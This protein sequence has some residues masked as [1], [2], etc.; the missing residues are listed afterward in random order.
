M[1]ER[2]KVRTRVV[3]LLLTVL[4]AGLPA[5]EAGKSKTPKPKNWLG[6]PSHEL[7]AVMGPPDETREK[8]NG[9][10]I[11]VWQRYPVVE[12]DLGPSG[13]GPDA[14][15]A[16]PIPGDPT[17]VAP[18]MIE[19]SVRVD[20]QGLIVKLSLPSGCTLPGTEKKIERLPEPELPHGQADPPR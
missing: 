14:T 4:F 15:D 8:K 1:R 3:S 5:A 10:K 11:L 13:E 16:P 20:A 12:R 9:S 7:V 17:L 19:C 18:R 6:K 2:A